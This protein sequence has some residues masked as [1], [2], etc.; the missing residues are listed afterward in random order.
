M[1]SKPRQHLRRRG[2]SSTVWG[3]LNTISGQCRLRAWLERLTAASQLFSKEKL[4]WYS[5]LTFAVKRRIRSRLQSV[6]PAGLKDLLRR[7]RFMRCSATRKRAMIPPSLKQQEKTI[8]AVIQDQHEAVGVD[9]LRFIGMGG[10]KNLL[11]MVLASGYTLDEAAVITQMSLSDIS[12]MV[13][14]EDVE[15]MKARMPSAIVRLADMKVMKDLV[16]GVVTKDTEAADRIAMRRRKLALDARHQQVS[17]IKEAQE[18]QEKREKEVTVRF[19][20]NRKEEDCEDR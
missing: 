15:A 9:R 16:A 12:G 11:A 4:L 14:P 13:Q 3:S 2:Q 17:E 6:D 18:M 8:L 10:I 19:R 7:L 1:D 5:G 20:V